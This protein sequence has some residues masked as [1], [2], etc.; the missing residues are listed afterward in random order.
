MLTSTEDQEL[1]SR[2]SRFQIG[3]PLRRDTVGN[4]THTQDKLG[5]MLSMTWTQ[6]G[7]QPNSLVKDK[8]QTSSNGSDSSN[9]VRDLLQ[10][11]STMKSP[12]QPGSDMVVIWTTLKENITHSPMLIK[13]KNSFSVLTP[14]PQRVKLN[15][16]RNGTLLLKWPQSLLEK[17]TSSI[18]TRCNQPSQVSPTSEESGNSTESICSRSDLP[19]SSNKVKSPKKTSTIS[20]DSQ[21]WTRPQPS[22]STS[23]ADSDNSHISP[24]MLTIKVHPESWK[25]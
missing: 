21:A 14:P 4:L 11:F 22:V 23:K 15:S 17:K 3:P 19:T 5:K 2:V 9:G 16:K 8:S 25:S 24:T 20:K 10:D 18:H 6:S 12:N 7:L 13:N 1:S